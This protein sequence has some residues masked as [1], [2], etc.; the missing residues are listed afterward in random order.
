MNLLRVANTVAIKMPQKS[1]ADIPMVT[2]PR[3]A[4][5]SCKS[6][7]D[8]VRLISAETTSKGAGSSFDPSS[9]MEAQAPKRIATKRAPTMELFMLVG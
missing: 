8:T 6:A 5:R 2:R 7:P 4:A 1:A 9:P 3:L